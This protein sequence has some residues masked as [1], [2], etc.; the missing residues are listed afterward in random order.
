MAGVEGTT[1]GLEGGMLT[2]HNLLEKNNHP[3]ES[4]SRQP[5]YSDTKNNRLTT[6]QE[7][8]SSQI[9]RYAHCKCTQPLLTRFTDG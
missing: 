3:V 6:G 2:I 7:F 9:I 8:P 4:C 5:L 1:L